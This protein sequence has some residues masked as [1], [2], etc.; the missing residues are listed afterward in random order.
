LLFLLFGVSPFILFL[1]LDRLVMRMSAVRFRAVAP[2][3]S[4]LQDSVPPRPQPASFRFAWLSWGPPSAALKRE[5]IVRITPSRPLGQ[6]LR[7]GTSCLG[8]WSDLSIILISKQNTP[9]SIR[10]E[11]LEPHFHAPKCP[12][13]A[14]LQCLFVPVIL[15]SPPLRVACSWPKRSF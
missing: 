4:N 15:S 1:R 5:L 10:F 11:A 2:V 12:F 7:L 13:E 6:R 9:E 3:H 14:W 8:L